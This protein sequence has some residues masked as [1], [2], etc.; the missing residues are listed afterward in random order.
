MK[1]NFTSEET[2]ALHHDRVAAGLSILPG[3]GQLYKGHY[4]AGCGFGVLGVVFAAWVM[5]LLRLSYAFG[6]LVAAF[7]VEVNWIAVLLNPI[8][9]Y[10]GLLPALLLWTA[11]AADAYSETDLR[12]HSDKPICRA[13]V[14]AT[15]SRR[16]S[17][18][19]LVHQ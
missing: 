8:T 3:L 12:Q 13:P 1:R 7:G 5:L 19:H 6:A 18:L 2:R 11:A 16:E 17:P 4:F 10:M 14:R 9:I 15:T